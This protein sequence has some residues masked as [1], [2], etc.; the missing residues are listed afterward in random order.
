M[1]SLDQQNAFRQRY[2]QSNPEW[3]PATEVYADLVR[4]HLTPDSKLLDL[5]CG[6]GGLV[7]QLD[8][9]IHHCYGFDP[10]FESLRQNRL[11]DRY[12][13]FSRINGLSRRL[14]M[15]SAQF[16]ILIA[17]WVLEH[18]MEPEEDFREFSRVLRPGGKF[19]FITPNKR[20]PI[21]KLNM[22]LGRLKGVQG[23]LVQHLYG[24]LS[25]DAFPTYYRANDSDEI[26]RLAIYCGMK[27][28]S[29]QTIVDP[30]YLAFN[31]PMFRF[32]C[33]IER[34]LPANWRVHLVG[35]AEKKNS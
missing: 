9:P 34:F 3:Q 17:S 13:G 2:H 32:S 24:R 5:G 22:A 15:A 12:P 27:I 26:N 28:E 25:V 21:A 4:K 10:D 18:L 23:R 16:D 33:F 6:R 7:E 11:A 14:P 31:E 19:I 20:H 1:L 8:Q 30:T 35:I 29:L